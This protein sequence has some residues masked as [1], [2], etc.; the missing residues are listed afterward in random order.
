[1][2]AVWLSAVFVYSAVIL[3]KVG[4]FSLGV[5]LVDMKNRISQNDLD[6][7]VCVEF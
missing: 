4:N 6:S 2:F 7:Q 3:Y 5:V 1:M